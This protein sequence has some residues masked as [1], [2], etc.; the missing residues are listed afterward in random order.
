MTKHVN[1]WPIS[2]ETTKWGMAP[3]AEVVPTGVTPQEIQPPEPT[4][5][6]ILK[7]DEYVVPVVIMTGSTSNKLYFE[8]TSKNSATF[9]TDEFFYF[10]G[11][12]QVL[13]KRKL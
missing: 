4:I 10:N 2:E 13:L 1:K 9:E 12:I 8:I 11:N 6:Y 5:E 7:P 3:R